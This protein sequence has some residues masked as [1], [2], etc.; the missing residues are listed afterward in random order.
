MPSVGNILLSQ[1]PVALRV[2]ARPA[3]PLHANSINPGAGLANVGQPVHAWPQRLTGRI[4]GCG[5]VWGDRGPSGAGLAPPVT[6]N[7]EQA[8][9]PVAGRGLCVPGGQAAAGLQLPRTRARLT[10]R[11]PVPRPQINER[12]VAFRY[13]SV[14]FNVQMTYDGRHTAHSTLQGSRRRTCGIRSL[15][16][17]P[18]NETATVRRVARLG[19]PVLFLCI[20]VPLFGGG[21]WRNILPFRRTIAPARGTNGW[22]APRICRRR[23]A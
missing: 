8:A 9:F 18:S 19:F 22:R 3:G 10:G 15:W 5:G 6:G 7:G 17:V 12:G 20:T 11:G 21:C 2:T 23:A 1:G 13:G 14:V 16:P 4:L